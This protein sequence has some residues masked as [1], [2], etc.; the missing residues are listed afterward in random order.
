MDS[1]LRGFADLFL[2]FGRAAKPAQ[3]PDGKAPNR[4][5]PRSE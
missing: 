5:A 4:R 3:K 1:K 2:F